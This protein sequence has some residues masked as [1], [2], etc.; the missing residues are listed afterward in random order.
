MGKYIEEHVYSAFKD[1]LQ[2]KLVK[3][4]TLYEL[5]DLI[6]EDLIEDAEIKID[7]QRAKIFFIINKKEYTI[8]RPRNEILIRN[9]NGSLKE[10]Q[11]DILIND[12]INFIIE[13]NLI[14]KQKKIKKEKS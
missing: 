11:Y 5:W 8:S 2:D 6:Y 3:K 4:T 12:A 10:E 13:N 7:L 1:Y 14:K 9:E